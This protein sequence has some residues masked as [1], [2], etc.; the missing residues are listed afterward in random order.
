VYHRITAGGVRV[1]SP[2]IFV[3]HCFCAEVALLVGDAAICPRRTIRAFR[4]VPPT[5]A[6]PFTK[7]PPTV[8]GGRRRRINLG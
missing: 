2:C 5:F 7:R 4:T 6:N 3:P 1:V 8:W